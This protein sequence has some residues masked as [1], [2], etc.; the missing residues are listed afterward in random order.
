MSD[1]DLT[2][3]ERGETPDSRSS[4]SE[5]RGRSINGKD[6]N[7]VSEYEKQRLS[8]IAENKKRMEALGLANLAKTLV[9]SAKNS[10]T[11]DKKGKRKLGEDNDADEDYK[12]GED[13]SSAEDGDGIDGLEEGD[14]DF[15]SGKVSASGGMKSKNKGSKAKRKTSVEKSNNLDDE[16]D[17][18]ALRQAIELSLRDSGVNSDAQVQGAIENVKRKNVKT[19]KITGGMK[20]KGSFT[21]RMQMNEDELIVNF[22]YFD[23]L[24]KGSISVSDMKRVAAAHDFTWSD[25]ELKDMIDCFDSDGDG[26]GKLSLCCFR[27]L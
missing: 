14:E 25:Q 2:D 24:W 5:E 20:R 16:D 10:R 18:N 21:S 17:D 12:P 6:V 7:V 23:E 19:Q 15:G 3:S 26:K 8:R 22:Y 9:G 13:S 4:D 11:I 1:R 27:T